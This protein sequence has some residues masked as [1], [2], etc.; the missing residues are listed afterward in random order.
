MRTF[1]N[2]REEIH[3]IYYVS[4]F[5]NLQDE[6]DIKDLES[7]FLIPETEHSQERQNKLN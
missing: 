5:Y 7:W 2:S 3:L 1:G 4:F 6:I